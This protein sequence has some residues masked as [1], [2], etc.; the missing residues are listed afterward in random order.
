MSCYLFVHFRE[1]RTPDGEQ[2]YFGVSRDGFHWEPVN[3]GRPVLWCYEGE[4]GA[5]DA[6][7]YYNKFTSKYYIIATDL[8]LAYNFRSLYHADWSYAATHGSKYLSAWESEDLLH[9]TGQRLLPIGNEDF[10]MLWAPDVIYDPAEDNYVIHWSSRHS[11]VDGMGRACIWCCR[12]RDMENFGTREIL[13]LHPEDDVIDSAMYEEDGRYYLFVKDQGKINHNILLSS[14]SI[15]GPFAMMP[16]FNGE[17]EKM[18]IGQY[19]AATAVKLDSGK[20]ALFLD[21][22]G[23][24]GGHGYVPFLADSLSDGRFVRA[25][26]EFSFPYGFK[27][28][29]I[30]KITEEQY[31]AILARD[32]E[33]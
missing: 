5:R 13:Y 25:D 7:I 20:W 29:T 4:K 33:E 10:G 8:S 9:W 19:E 32:W 31:E 27:H 1:K 30:L 23:K 12:T 15:R 11:G 26:E 17:M 16:Q 28:G 18:E 6:T 3:G 24:T 14:D 21:Y 2:I 22:Y